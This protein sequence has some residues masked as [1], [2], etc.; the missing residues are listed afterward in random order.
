M[1]HIIISRLLEVI[2][3]HCLADVLFVSACLI[4]LSHSVV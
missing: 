2:H 4:D 3:C 1:F